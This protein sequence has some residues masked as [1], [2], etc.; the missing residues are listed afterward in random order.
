MNAD[1]IPIDIHYNKL[2]DWLINRR[3]CQQQWQG[4]ALVVREKINTAIQDMPPVDE[5]TELLRGTYINY[6]HCQKIISLLKET[7]DGSKNIFGWYSSQRMKDWLDIIKCY[8]KDGVYLA[9]AA[10]MLMRN[11]NYE[12]PALKRQVAKCQQVQKDCTR[13]E[14]EY[15]SIASEIKDKYHSSCRQM[16]VKGQRVKAELV[17]LVKDMTSLYTEIERSAVKL[18]PACQYYVAFV[19]FMLGSPEKGAQRTMLLMHFI[20]KGN[21]TTYEWKYGQPPAH[22]EEPVRDYGIDEEKI[23]EEKADE[24]DWGDIGTGADTINFDISLEDTQATEGV[25]PE[26]GIDWGDDGTAAIIEVVDDSAGEAPSNDDADTARG[27]NALTILDNTETRNLL[28][29]QLDELVAFL[30]QRVQELSQEGNVLSDS[31]FSSAAAEV[32]LDLSTIKSMLND[33]KELLAHMTSKKMQNLFLIRS[34][35]SY[36]HRMADSLN[37]ILSDSE[38]M[39]SLS[40][41]MVLRREEAAEEEKQIQPRIELLRKHTR[42]L[43][44]QIENEISKKYKNRRVN[45]M[46]E[47]NTV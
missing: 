21:T 41:L 46:G 19:S 26:D 25:D 8:E 33:V 30:S 1:D 18:K 16:G 15:A 31:Q 17:D 44:K 3:H 5:I 38:K 40:R 4:A 2:L 20:E 14:A 36:V 28:I 43:Q 10:Q 47:I 23:E 12:I 13:K 9:E 22:I 29:N 39:T 7:D 45:I 27:S 35:P 6:F 37:K 42:E 24:I 32:Q 11:V 34:S